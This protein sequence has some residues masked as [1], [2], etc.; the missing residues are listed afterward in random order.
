MSMVAEKWMNAS[1]LAGK[2]SKS[3]TRRRERISQ[4]DGWA[5]RR[6]AGRGRVLFRTASRRTGL[7]GFPVIRLS[8]DYCVSGLA[9]RSEW[10]RSWQVS[11]ATTVLRRR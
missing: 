5:A 1:L 10:I 6:G 8:S 11:Q 2:A 7:D 3:R 4:P 9:G